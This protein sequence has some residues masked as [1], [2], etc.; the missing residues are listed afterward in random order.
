MRLLVPPNVQVVHTRAKCV[1]NVLVSVVCPCHVKTSWIAEWV[2]NDF[3]VVFVETDLKLIRVC[4]ANYT[5]QATFLHASY[6]YL[7]SASILLSWCLQDL[8]DKGTIL[9]LSATRCRIKG[10]MNEGR[11]SGGS[12]LSREDL[13]LAQ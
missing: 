12:S 11:G 5:K 3:L 2:R 7:L 10:G 1:G 8:I 9:G 13:V 6:Q 4:S